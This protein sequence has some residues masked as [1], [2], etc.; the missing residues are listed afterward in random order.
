M[1]QRVVDALS[2][3]RGCS[4]IRILDARTGLFHHAAHA[5]PGPRPHAE[6]D[7]VH[8]AQ[9]VKPQHGR[10]DPAIDRDVR[11]AERGGHAGRHSAGAFPTPQP[12]AARLGGRSRSGIF[13]RKRN[14]RQKTK[15]GE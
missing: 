2:L 5:G 12:G 11:R 8:K 6:E 14:G 7:I 9:R 4:R 13:G 10:I 3:V 1:H 15:S